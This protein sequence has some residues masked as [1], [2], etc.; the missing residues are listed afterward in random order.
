[1]TDQKGK[2]FESRVLS[3][4]FLEGYT[5]SQKG[6]AGARTDRFRVHKRLFTLAWEVDLG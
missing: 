5:S 1:M 6:R 4:R 3:R 2:T